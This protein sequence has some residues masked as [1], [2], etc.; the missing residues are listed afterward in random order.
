MKLLFSELWFFLQMTTQWYLLEKLWNTTVRTDTFL[1][2]TTMPPRRLGSYVS[3]MAPSGSRSSMAAGPP[4][5]SV[6]KETNVEF[7]QKFS[8]FF[9]CH[10]SRLHN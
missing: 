6:R 1:N 2:M 9:A 7:Y 8:L 3:L 4:A 5:L 10:F